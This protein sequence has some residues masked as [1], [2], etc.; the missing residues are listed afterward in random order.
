MST[1]EGYSQAD[2]ARLARAWASADRE[3]DTA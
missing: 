2:R 3:S 1:P